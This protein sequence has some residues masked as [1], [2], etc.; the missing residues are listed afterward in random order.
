MD[1]LDAPAQRRRTRAAEQ[2]QN[3]M[4]Q[5]VDEAARS[6]SHATVLSVELH[7]TEGELTW[8]AEALHATRSSL[9]RS[10]RSA[11][12]YHETGERLRIELRAR[13]EEQEGLVGRLEKAQRVNDEW[14]ERVRSVSAEFESTAADWQAQLTM[15]D[16]KWRAMVDAL[17]TRLGAAESLNASDASRLQQ[18]GLENESLASRLLASQEDAA[19]Q[20]EAARKAQAAEAELQ[21]RAAAIASPQGE[22]MARTRRAEMAHSTHAR[23][24]SS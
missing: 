6:E 15:A 7:D 18:L 21:V 22:R 12:E 17:R 4:T 11:S 9:E 8:L 10:E 5:L 16:G 2:R 24:F 14:Q 23:F 19:S 3:N 1:D 20:K 13:Q